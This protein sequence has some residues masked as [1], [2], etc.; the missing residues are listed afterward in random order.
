[1]MIAKIFLS[2]LGFTLNVVE[3]DSGI[4]MVYNRSNIGC[5]RIIWDLWFAFLVMWLVHWR[6]ELGYWWVNNDLRG[7]FAPAS[8][9]AVIL[10]DQCDSVYDKIKIIMKIKLC[11][12]KIRWN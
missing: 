4:R 3:E 10:Y 12:W 8:W 2:S 7:M 9:V 5:N 1:M 11:E 6:L